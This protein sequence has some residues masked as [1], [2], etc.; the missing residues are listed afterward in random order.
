MFSSKAFV[1]AET[2]VKSWLLTS[3]LDNRID[4]KLQVF[5]LSH[6]INHD[7]FSLL[8]ASFAKIIQTLSHFQRLKWGLQPT[9]M[10]FIENIYSSTW[11]LNPESNTFS[12]QT[13]IRKRVCCNVSQFRVGLVSA[14][15]KR[16][17]EW[18]LDENLG[19]TTLINIENGE[20]MIF[21]LPFYKS[22]PYSSQTENVLDG[23]ERGCVF[24]CVCVK[25]L[26]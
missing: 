26:H 25:A 17:H 5:F 20:Q 16:P 3:I 22:F 23:E 2:Q 14:W 8:I 10:A 6:S 11:H 4:K 12:I 1:W 21:L 7:Q 18:V 13:T 15:W 9:F 19:A 24:V